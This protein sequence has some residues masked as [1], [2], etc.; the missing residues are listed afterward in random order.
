MEIVIMVRFMP[1]VPADADAYSHVFSLPKSSVAVPV[2]VMLRVTPGPPDASIV[3]DAAPPSCVATKMTTVG[4]ATIVPEN[5]PVE[6]LPVSD[7]FSVGAPASRA[8]SDVTVDGLF[9]RPKF[10]HT[11]ATMDE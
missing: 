4:Q 3:C 1:G 10:S 6:L 8:V 11:V 5:A 9:E 2:A 7:P